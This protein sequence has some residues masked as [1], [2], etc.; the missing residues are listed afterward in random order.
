MRHV[1][2]VIHTNWHEGER[3]L[4][5][6]SR[7][8]IGPGREERAEAFLLEQGE[9]LSVEYDVDHDVEVDEE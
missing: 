5:G 2:V 3:G 4:S 9:R 7:V 6:V 1:S 8:F